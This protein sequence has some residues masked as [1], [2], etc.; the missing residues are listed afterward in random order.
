VVN[1]IVMGRIDPI[2]VCK[3][4]KIR[5]WTPDQNQDADAWKINFRK[6]HDLWVMDNKI[7][8]IRANAQA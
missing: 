1:W 7:A 5:I 2:A 3:T 4:D 6:Y 8:H